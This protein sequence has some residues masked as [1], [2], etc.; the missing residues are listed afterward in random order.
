MIKNKLQHLTSRF[1]G[2]IDNGHLYFC[3]SMHNDEPYKR[4]C[5]T[6]T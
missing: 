4:P 3:A 5:F 6:Q 1:N 2:C